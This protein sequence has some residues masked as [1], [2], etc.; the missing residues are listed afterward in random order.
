MELRNGTVVGLHTV[1]PEARPAFEEGVSLVLERWT[2]L[3][4]AIDQE[5]GGA[6]SKQKA[7]QLYADILNWFYS[8]KEHYADDLEVDLEEI[9]LSDFN[10]ETEDG[11]PLEVAKQLVQF[12]RECLQGDF[13][14]IERLRRIPPAIASA[15]VRERVDR[16]G[17]VLDEEGG[18]ANREDDDMD[19]DQAPPAIPLEP[20]GPIID[21]DGFELVQPK[22]LA[23]A[24]LLRIGAQKAEALGLESVE[25]PDVRPP[26]AVAEALAK[27][28]AK[29]QEAEETFNNSDFVKNLRDKSDANR[30]SNRKALQDKYCY[31]QAEMG[32]GDCAGLQLIPGMTKNGKQKTPGWLAKV[33]GKG[34]AEK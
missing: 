12:H 10:C 29:F 16:D 23:G 33:L 32:V 5:W 34:E 27:N 8:N 3:C 1:P 25:F 4:L 6:N 11:S 9:L 22:G 28:K 15:C 2:A 14:L 31:R 26:Q 17:T 20:K 19:M 24:A 13:S 21:E 30:A 7:Q 18:S